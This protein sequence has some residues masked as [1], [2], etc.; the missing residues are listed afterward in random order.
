MTK[1]TINPDRCKSCELCI[2][3][4]PK[5]IIEVDN[6][7]INAKGYHPAHVI[8]QELCIGCKSCATMCPDC[9]ITIER[10]DD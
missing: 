9:A 5:N 3:V 7:F 4:C 10:G 6:D 1:V 2:S 8:N